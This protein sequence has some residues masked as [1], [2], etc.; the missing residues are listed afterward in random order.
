MD[1]KFREQQHEYKQAPK[2]KNIVSMQ[3][4]ITCSCGQSYIVTEKEGGTRCP[5]CKKDV[6]IGIAV[7]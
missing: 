3:I 4:D 5:N 7:M 2:I 6:D 1:T